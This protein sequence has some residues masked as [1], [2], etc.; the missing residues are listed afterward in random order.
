MNPR[1]KPGVTAW[2]NASKQWRRSATRSPHRPPA[3]ALLARMPT[4]NRSRLFR[5][6][7]PHAGSGIR[8]S[9]GTPFD[10]GHPRSPGCRPTI[11]HGCSAVGRHMPVLASGRAAAHNR[12]RPASSV[13]V[14]LLDRRRRNVRPI[15]NTAQA[16]AVKQ[17]ERRPATR[18]ALLARMPPNSPLRP[19]ARGWPHASSGIRA[20]SGTLFNPGHPRDGLQLASDAFLSVKYFTPSISI[21][22]N[23]SFR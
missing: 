2:P 16:A 9:S 21:D 3:P 13:G 17:C 1:E 23:L 14:P 7:W 4:D 18:T 22:R 8:A 5:C 12:H 19:F 20:S 15:A 6:G 11:D 10:P